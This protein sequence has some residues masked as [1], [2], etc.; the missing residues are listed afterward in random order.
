MKRRRRAARGRHRFPEG[1][2]GQRQN[3]SDRDEGEEEGGKVE[4]KLPR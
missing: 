1:Q 4:A 2:Q 3:G